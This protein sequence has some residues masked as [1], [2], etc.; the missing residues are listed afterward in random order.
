[1]ILAAHQ[2]NDLPWCGYFYKI[3]Y[4]D[5]F[6]ILDDVQFTKNS[7]QNRTRIKGPQ[8]PIWLTQP[9]LHSGRAWQ[10]TAA[11]EFDSRIDWRTKH[12]KT[13]VPRS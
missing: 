10:S 1:M 8:G 2:S 9:V 13:L 5:I 4:C 7:Y 6:V 3:A 12:V 11:V